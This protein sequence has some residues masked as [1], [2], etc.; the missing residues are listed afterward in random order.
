MTKIQTAERVSQNETSDNYVFQRS[1]LAYLEAAKHVHGKVLE[2]GTGS[3]YGIEHIS[4]VAEEF[5]TVDKHPVPTELILGHENVKFFQAKA[6]RLDIFPSDYFDFV[7][8]FQVIEHIS[9]DDLFIQEIKR[10][11]KPGGKVILTTPNRLMSLTRNPWHVRE[12]THLELEN[13]L[14]PL[15]S[16]VNVLGVSGDSK[17]MSYYEENKKGVQQFLKWDIFKMN[18]WLPRF[19]LRIPYDWSNRR[20]R[21]NISEHGKEITSSNYLISEFDDSCFDLFCI[22]TN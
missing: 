2:I 3:G 15:F 18:Q 13:L 4:T 21:K 9:Q 10:V 20:N 5:V 7:I 19:L 12:Y 14:K 1:L 6:P 22:A 8:S 16:E 17:V 11:L